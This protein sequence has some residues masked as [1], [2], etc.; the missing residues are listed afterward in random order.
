M[1]H[2]EI[3][4]RFFP[5]PTSESQQTQGLQEVKIDFTPSELKEAMPYLAESPEGFHEA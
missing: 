2:S 1:R 3:L 5:I 4:H